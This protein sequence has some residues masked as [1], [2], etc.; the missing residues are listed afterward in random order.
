MPLATV[1]FQ[2]NRSINMP[3]LLATR[4]IQILQRTVAGSFHLGTVF[5]HHSSCSRNSP[6]RCPFLPL[7]NLS[8]VF[9]TSPFA[10]DNHG[11]LYNPRNHCVTDNGWKSKD[12]EQLLWDE[13]L[14]MY[15]TFP[16]THNGRHDEQGQNR[17][18]WT[19]CGAAGYREENDAQICTTAFGSSRTS[20]AGTD[21]AFQAKS[22]VKDSKIP[23][24]KTKVDRA[25]L[26]I[27][28]TIFTYV[29][30]FEAWISSKQRFTY[31][32]PYMGL[33]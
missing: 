20:V 10:S 11:S 8:T 7:R 32:I 17:Y 9:H 23:W 19:N 21:T 26:R 6:R 25:W 30:L 29:S 13:A 22:N 16:C 24:P 2:N 4:E 15:K 1:C 5:Y 3:L 14:P 18:D 31:S 12:F 28:Q 33:I 27:V